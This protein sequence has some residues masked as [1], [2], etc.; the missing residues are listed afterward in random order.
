MVEGVSPRGNGS[1]MQ[2][3]GTGAQVYDWQDLVDGDGIARGPK[4]GPIRVCSPLALMSLA[5]S[6]PT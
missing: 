2:A 5:S 6:E 3:T 4:G 1:V